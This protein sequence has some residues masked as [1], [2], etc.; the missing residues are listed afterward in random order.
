M[1]TNV[2]E[3]ILEID[4]LKSI[5]RRTYISDTS[6][7]ENSGEHS[8]HVAIM[9]MTLFEAYEKK[10]ETDL[11]V[12]LKMLL[13]HDVVEIDAGDTYAFDAVGYNDKSEREQRAA[14]RL[15]GILPEPIGMEFRALWDEYEEGTSNEAVYAH[16]IDHIQPLLLNVATKGKSWQEHRI[17]AQQVL[18]RNEWI[19]ETSPSIHSQVE[20]W[21]N[22]AV[23]NAWLL[24]R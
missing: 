16:M 19:K 23:E 18:K 12:S 3:F 20:K 4:K 24:K 15:F 14:D 9:A 10:E 1:L 11:F 13:L 2:M 22:T 7:R 5:E 21:V 17:K 8:W 6:R